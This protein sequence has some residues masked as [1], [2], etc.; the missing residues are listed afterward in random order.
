MKDK[1]YTMKSYISTL[2]SLVIII[3]S[4]T[5][6]SGQQVSGTVTSFKN[7]P[8]RNVK[9]KSSKTSTSV[10]TDSLGRYSISVADEDILNFNASG[11]DERKVRLKKNPVVD[12]DLRYKFSEGSFSEAVE[13]KHITEVNLTRAL[14]KYQSKGEKNYNRYQ[15]IFDLIR[16]E[17]SNVRVVGTSV[18]SVK[19]ISFSMSAQVLYVVDDTIISDISYISPVM[20]KKIE[21]LDGIYASDYGM[22]GANGVIR[23]TLKNK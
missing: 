16:G 23:I 10:L 11:F 14:E 4:V 3:G 17:I 1:S 6:I 2:V 18:Y 22:R 12:V 8:L 20:V 7:I 19:A 9:V 15:N 21:Y 5:D 13:N